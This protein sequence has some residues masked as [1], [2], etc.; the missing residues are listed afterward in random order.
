[1][2]PLVGEDLMVRQAITFD[3]LK[4]EVPEVPAQSAGWRLGTNGTLM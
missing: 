1:M 3:Q 2:A 4:G